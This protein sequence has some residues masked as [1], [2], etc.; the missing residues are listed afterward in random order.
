MKKIIAKK[1]VQIYKK[2][3]KQL[4]IEW[5]SSKINDIIGDCIGYMLYNISTYENIDAF[6]NQQSVKKI[7][8]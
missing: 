4:I 6:E 8:I 3:E 1:C 5:R 2:G 7:D